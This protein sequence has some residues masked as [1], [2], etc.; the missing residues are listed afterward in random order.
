VQKAKREGRD[1]VSV[2]DE[3]GQ[4]ERPAGEVAR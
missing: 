3:D 4:A 2:D 1:R